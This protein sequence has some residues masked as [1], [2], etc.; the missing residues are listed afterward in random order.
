MDNSSP[1]QEAFLR[2]QR[3]FPTCL[4]GFPHPLGTAGSDEVPVTRLLEEAISRCKWAALDQRYNERL[5]EL[6]QATNASFE[7]S[8]EAVRIQCRAFHDAMDDLDR[9]R[10]ETFV[11]VNKRRSEA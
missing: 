6:R 9:A 1:I 5:K 11:R 2:L 8:Q 3:L 7:S 4:A 10:R